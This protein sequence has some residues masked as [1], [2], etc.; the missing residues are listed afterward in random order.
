M[1]ELVT[2]P[3]GVIHIQSNIGLIEVFAFLFIKKKH[4]KLS[5]KQI[6][7]SVICR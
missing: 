6:A 7:H 2:V 5:V 3:R 1:T 4:L